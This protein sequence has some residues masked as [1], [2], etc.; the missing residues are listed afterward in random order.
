[1]YAICIAPRLKCVTSK[2]L[3][4]G[5]HSFYTANTPYLQC[6]HLVSV[7]QRA[8]SLAIV[9]LVY[10]VLYYNTTKN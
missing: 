9:V 10:F 1:M 8:P 5:S 6:L 7:H 2:A 3:R 4:Y